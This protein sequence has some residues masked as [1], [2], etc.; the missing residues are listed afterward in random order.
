MDDNQI[1]IFNQPYFESKDI[2]TLVTTDP[3][4][5]HSSYYYRPI[6]SLSFLADVVISGGLNAWM[7]HL[8][9][10]LLFGMIGCL[11]FLLLLKFNVPNRVAFIGT[12]IFCVHPIFVTAAAWIPA[13][14]DLLL[15]LFCILSMIFLKMFIEKGG[16]NNLVIVWLT[17]TLGLFCKETAAFLP[18][19]FLVYFLMYAPTRKIT[20]PYILLGVSI[21]LSCFIWLYLRNFFAA[22]IEQVTLKNLFT[23]FLSIPVA[24]S[25]LIMFPIDYSPLPS[26]TIT[27]VFVGIAVTTLILLLVY[28][29]TK[30][31]NKELIFYLLW[32]FILLIPNF[33]AFKKDRIDYIDHRFLLP[34]IGLLLFVLSIFPSSIKKDE[35][36]R[37]IWLK[38]YIWVGV[39][40][41]L[42]IVSF[43]KTD[44]YRNPKSYYGAVVKFSPGN[45]SFAY[46]NLGWWKHNVIG[47]VR[48]AFDDYNEAIFYNNENAEAYNGR[49]ILKAIK[50]DINGALEDFNKA[51]LYN[52]TLSPAYVNRGHCRASINEAL[53]DYNKAI[54]LNNE[55]ELA[56]LSRGLLYMQT[57][58]LHNSLSDFD[59]AIRLNG[60]FVDAY[61]SRA[62]VKS[63]M[64]NLNEAMF[65]IKSVLQIEPNNIRALLNRAVLY[66]ELKDAEKAL[67]DCNRVLYINPGNEQAIWILNQ[68]VQP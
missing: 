19:L 4:L 3:Y 1:L 50:E 10:I 22:P 56:F 63:K 52:P 31:T 35:K 16:I 2:Q 6:Q 24:F 13:R 14:G 11:L 27:K 7:F 42:G 9:N 30:R 34:M 45:R 37:L 47:D 64:R 36:I 62:E 5:G 41:V 65:D 44:V 29:K 32:F 39:V 46:N 48:G 49:G 40:I 12:L 28:K 57:G 67:Q 66:L 23:N 17:F 58:E 26:F 18:I 54:E 61:L 15:S 33:L 51:I 20:L 8:T 55:N 53:D 68:I 60:N 25:Q 43:Y 59:D 38:D 21:S